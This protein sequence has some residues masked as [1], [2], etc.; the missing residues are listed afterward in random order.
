MSR[1]AGNGVIYGIVP[2][3]GGAERRAGKAVLPP[4]SSMLVGRKECRFFSLS[5]SL[6]STTSTVNTVPA[7]VGLFHSLSI[8]LLLVL[9]PYFF[10]FL[11]IV[12]SFVPSAVNVSA[13]AVVAA[14]PC[15]LLLLPLFLPL[16]VFPANVTINNSILTVS[17]LHL[18]IAFYN[19]HYC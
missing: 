8:S 2:R 14:F 3:H 15:V 12:P 1:D 6:A 17:F 11:N 4:S 5:L 16:L 13:A 19:F 18:Y 7:S 10:P 9:L